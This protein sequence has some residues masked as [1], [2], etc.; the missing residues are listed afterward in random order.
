MIEQRDGLGSSPS[1][2]VAP[3]LASRPT[4]APRWRIR[5]RGLPRRQG[6]AARSCFAA[7]DVSSDPSPR[8]SSATARSPSATATGE[9]CGESCRRTQA[10]SGSRSRRSGAVG[11]RKDNEVYAEIRQRVADAGS[12]PKTKALTAVLQ[13]FTKQA[14][15]LTATPEPAEPEPVPKWLTDALLSVVRLPSSQVEEMSLE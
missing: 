13:V 11:Y 3:T 2:K 15:D 9:S 1:T 5:C 12:P 4:Q 8:V 10:T 14:R 7:E 6:L